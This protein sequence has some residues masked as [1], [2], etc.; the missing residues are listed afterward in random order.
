MDQA[1]C[2][3]VY[4][5]RTL[6]LLIVIIYF[7]GCVSNKQIF[8]DENEM[9]IQKFVPVTVQDA[10]GLD[11]CSFL[12]VKDSIT[13]FQPVELPDSLMK[14]GLKLWIKFSVVNQMSICMSGQSI[15]L[16]TVKYR[17]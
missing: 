7:G 13:S 14:D 17:K 11:G 9:I 10:T 12:L 2:K 16:S 5:S 4:A 6:I 3:V 15:K 8:E 1:F